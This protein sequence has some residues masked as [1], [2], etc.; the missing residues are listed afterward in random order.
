MSMSNVNHATEDSRMDET[1][2]AIANTSSARLLA[3]YGV[4][5]KASDGQTVQLP[6][7]VEEGTPRERNLTVG[8]GVERGLTF[9]YIAETLGNR[10]DGYKN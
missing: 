4:L 2:I 1:F 6:I 9:K 10:I 7:V 3:A 8:Q 5:V